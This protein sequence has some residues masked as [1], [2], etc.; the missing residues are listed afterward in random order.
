MKREVARNLT[1][2]IIFQREFH[3]DFEERYPRLI[4]ENNIRGVQGEYSRKTIEGVLE[5]ID[6]LDEIIRGNLRG[7]KFERLS[8]HVITVLRLGIYEML[9]NDDIPAKVALNEAVKLA[10][11][12]SEPKEA[13][14]VNGLLNTVYKN[15]CAD[16]D[17][18]Q[19]NA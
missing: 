3:D 19:D 1:Y 8:L 17:K 10:H 13:N 2:Q 11:R 15:Y 12:Y 4:E 18:I 5:N 7:W 16:V 9:F 6:R 14:F